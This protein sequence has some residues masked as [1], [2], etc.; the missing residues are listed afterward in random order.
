[1]TLCCKVLQRNSAASIS[2]RAQTTGGNFV[3]GP[4]PPQ[5]GDI[6]MSTQGIIMTPPRR[7]LRLDAE[8]IARSSAAPSAV[9]A[10]C[11][12]QHILTICGPRVCLSAVDLRSPQ[13]VRRSRDLLMIPGWFASTADRKKTHGLPVISGARKHP[14]DKT[15]IFDIPT[16]CGRFPG[17]ADSLGPLVCSALLPNLNL[18][19]TH[20]GSIWMFQLAAFPHCTGAGALKDL[21]RAALGRPRWEAKDPGNSRPKGLSG[22]PMDGFHVGSTDLAYIKTTVIVLFPDVQRRNGICFLWF[23]HPPTFRL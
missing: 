14:E 3:F 11:L 16:I 10:D 7:V 5:T 13:I 17:T 21:K 1:M 18:A 2:S 6:L 15:E 20:R 9:M 23:I 22:V 19:P 12:V 8:R 4:T